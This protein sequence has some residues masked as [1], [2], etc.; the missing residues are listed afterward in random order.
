MGSAEHEFQ[1]FQPFFVDLDSPPVLTVGDEISLP[2]VLRNYG[3]SSATMDISFGAAPWFEMLSPAAQQSTVPSGGSSNVVFSFRTMKPT[4]AGKQRVT[5]KNHSDGDAVEKLVRVHPDGEPRHAAAGA[6]VGDS[7]HPMLIHVP[8][9]T[10]AGSLFTRLTI[11][12]NLRSHISK[13]IENILERPYGC[14]EQTISS[15]YPGVLLLRLLD[16]SGKASSGSSRAQRYVQ[17][18]YD[19]LTNYFDVSGGLTYWGREERDENPDLALTAY[20]MEF[21]KDASS[22][23]AVDES[24]ITKARDWLLQQQQRDGSWGWDAAKEDPGTV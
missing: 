14:G 15:A 20:G 7:S 12:P 17:Q 9:N 4:E 3:K 6:I 19:R 5:A 2:V 21:L 24:R 8:D 13:S 16:G 1:S 23:I 18:A 22:F 11:Y 10:I